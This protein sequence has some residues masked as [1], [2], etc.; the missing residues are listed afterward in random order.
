MKILI[1][2]AD[3]F[4]GKNLKTELMNRN[5]N[6][7]AAIDDCGE[8][9]VLQRYVDESDL[10]FHLQTIYRSDDAAAFERINTGTTK[11]VIE[12]IG[13]RKKDLIYVSSTQAENQSP[14]GI[15]KRKAE[16]AVEA[17]AASTGNKAC[18]IRLANEFGKWCPPNLNSVVAT[19]CDNI[20]GEKEIQINNPDAPLKLVYI[21][22]IIDGLLHALQEDCPMY[23]GITPA[24]DTTVGRLADTIKGFYRDRKAGNVPDTGDDLTKKL[25]STY[26]SYLPQDRFAMPLE[27]HTDERG[28]FTELIHFGG[29]GQVSVNISKPG[30]TKGNHWH[31]TKTERFIVIKGCGIIRLR[32]IGDNKVIEYPV[33]GDRIE[34]VD[35]PPGYTHNITNTGK[36]DM[37]TVIWANEIFKQEN[38]DTYFEEV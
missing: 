33:S 5:Y 14:Y 22:D 4:I 19:F 31:H 23:T 26:L 12:L 18:I 27:P 36:T 28:S 10:I 7:V 8:T 11:K 37:F 1:T 3:S 17:W 24:Y 35:I 2:G 32:K 29:L 25:Y 6:E 20:A 16:E 30:V 13:N 15:S 38:A 9:E 34:A 21:D